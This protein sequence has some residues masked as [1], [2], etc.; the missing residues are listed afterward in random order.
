MLR[1]KREQMSK[2][3]DKHVTFDEVIRSLID[4]DLVVISERRGLKK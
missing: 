4:W 3:L 1:D 2:N